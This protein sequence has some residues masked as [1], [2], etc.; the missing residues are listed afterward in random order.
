[1]NR[2][3]KYLVN[4]LMLSCASILIRAISVSFNVYL[5]GK[6]GAE[7]MGLITLIYSVYGLFITLATSG[8]GLAVT[9][10]VSAF[11]SENE[12]G[13][14][15][16]KSYTSTAKILKSSL[17]YALIFSL[18]AS[19][20][21]FVSAGSIGAL[22][23][24]DRRTVPSLRLLAFSLTPIALTSV[25]NGYFNGV[26]RV[27]KSVF[28]QLSEQGVR[29][30][31]T[32]FLL[33][34]ILPKSVENACVA[35]IGAGVVAEVWSALISGI[36]LLCDRKKHTKNTYTVSKIGN[37]PAILESEGASYDRL[38]FGGVF[39]LAFPMGVSGYVR[40]AL[41]TVEH[42]A[43][44]WGLKKS[45]GADPLASYG[46]LHGMVFPILMFPSAVLGAFSSLLVPELS[47]AQARGDIRSIR[48]TVS[49]VISLSLLFSVGVSGIF[50]A[51]SHEIGIA[52]YD[53]AKAGEY[54]R[55]LSPLIPLM[56]LDGAVD[57]MLKGLGEQLYCMRVNIG[58]SVISVILIFTLLPAYGMWGYVAVIF[59]TELYNT[60]FS[61]LRLL[62]VTN[63]KT[64]CLKWVGKPLL[65]VLTSTV[66]TR[67]F[68]DGP[69]LSV[70]PLGRPL[71]AAEIA[72]STLIYII[73]VLL[74]GR[75]KRFR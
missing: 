50:I 15:N 61:I 3:K 21:L 57:S 63:I 64:P 17:A 2:L 26:R 35:I 7:G 55:I 36:L 6:T 8:I 66:I 25:I 58:D 54:I 40:S 20:V 13:A 41:A 72:S 11:Y 51:Y 49:A 60:S 70:L 42:I 48:R 38:D 37:T 43:I 44:P 34:I 33:L 4:G 24:C 67:L 32:A 47:S 71:L 19:C 31:L 53:S 30:S 74:F 75:L 9:R 22:V 52:L 65:A 18:T 69:Y 59:I 28:V 45:G 12:A 5:S 62:K 73:A 29:I 39:S 16:E 10:L 68:F 23:L 1:M 27:Y 56:Y 14:V 46:I